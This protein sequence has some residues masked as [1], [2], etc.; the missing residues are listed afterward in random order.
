MNRSTYY[1]HF[2]TETAPRVKKNQEIATN[3][4]KIVADYDKRVDAYKITHILKRDYGIKISPGRVYRLIKTLNLPRMSTQKPVLKD[5]SEDHLKYYNHLHQ[6]FNPKSPNMV[7][8]S[9][10]T[11]IKVNGT[12]YYLCIIMDLFS[13]KIIAW[14]LS[15]KPNAQLVT[16]TFQKAYTN[17][18]SPQGLMFHSDRGTQYTAMSFRKLLD[19]LV[20]IQSFSKKGYPFDNACCESFFKYLK[21]EECNRRNYHTKKEL[22]LSIFQYIEGFYNSKRPHGSLGL[23]SPNEKEKE[24]WSK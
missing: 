4:L 3:I 13:R 18:N 21:K 14:N 7:W 11:Y 24:Y 22:E 12:W 1:K 17:R 9:D 5:H 20:V 23:M 15:S 8:A 19:A 16:T 6:A 10:F 2:S